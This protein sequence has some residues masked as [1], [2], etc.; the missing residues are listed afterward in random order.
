MTGSA[1]FLEQARQLAPGD[2]A[3]VLELAVLAAAA[4]EVERETELYRSALAEAGD[5][6]DLWPV[7]LRLVLTLLRSNRTAESRG[8]VEELARLVDH[9]EGENP[10]GALPGPEER[11]LITTVHGILLAA[12]GK[13]QEARRQ[14]RT[15]AVYAPAAGALA[16]LDA[17]EGRPGEGT[18]PRADPAKG[19]T[20]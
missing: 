19:W 13:R 2:I 1:G 17:T 9:V 20:P 12:D 6:A 4:G 15:V 8:Q 14:L 7:R 11:Q 3:A 16:V 18:P 10:G 5:R